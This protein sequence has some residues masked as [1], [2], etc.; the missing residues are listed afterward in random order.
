MNQVK[1]A[2]KKIQHWNISFYTH[3]ISN[4]SLTNHKK[5]Y[6]LN[7]I[8]DEQVWY[9]AG[10]ESQSASKSRPV[11]KSG[12]LFAK[13]TYFYYHYHSSE[14]HLQVFLSQQKTMLI[15]QSSDVISKKAACLLKLFLQGF[16]GSAPSC[17]KHLY[18]VTSK[19]FLDQI[20]VIPE[21]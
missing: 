5:W 1:L 9:I 21:N 11:G 6:G 18:P 8:W 15:H 14:Y 20:S 10:P 2:T 7:M 16:Q 3:S 19:L 17:S 12:Y 13:L 4:K